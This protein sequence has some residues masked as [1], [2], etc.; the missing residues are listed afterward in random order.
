[1]VKDRSLIGKKT[2]CPKCKYRFVVTEPEDEL[3]DDEDTPPP[4]K[5]PAPSKATAGAAAAARSK[6]SAA[7]E[8]DED[9]APKKKSAGKKKARPE[10][11]EN[12]DDREEQPQTKKVTTKNKN[13][14]YI[15]IGIG[16]VALIA[17]GVGGY[18]MFG[19][20]GGGSSSGGGSVAKGGGG[21]G[22]GG[23][24]GGK[25]R[26]GGGFGKGKPGGPSTTPTD[27]NQPTR[28]TPVGAN[29]FL[30]LLP[31]DTQSVFSSD[32]EKLSRTIPFQLLIGAFRED[33]IESQLGIAT[34]NIERFIQARH[35]VQQRTF[36]IIRTRQ[37]YSEES[38]RRHLELEANE[39]V[40][41]FAWYR[42]GK[43]DL[44][45]LMTILNASL[46]QIPWKANDQ[47]QLRSST[48]WS[49]GRPMAT[50]FYDKNTLI[51][52][53][54]EWLRTFLSEGRTPKILVDELGENEPKQPDDQPPEG[55]PEQPDQPSQ[56]PQGQ[57]GSVPSGPAA[58]PEGMQGQPG[59][60]MPGGQPKFGPIGLPGGGPGQPKSP[61]PPPRPKRRPSGFITVDPDMKAVIDRLEYGNDGR[62]GQ[63]AETV[64]DTRT[65]AG[66]ALVPQLASVEGD[67]QKLL[68]EPSNLIGLK[69]FGHAVLEYS[70][71]KFRTRLVYLFDRV[72]T[73]VQF[74]ERVRLELQRLTP[75]LEQ[76]TETLVVVQSNADN[77]Q[78]GFPGD[79][80]GFPGMPGPGY[81]KGGMPGPGYPK[82]S[83]PG[84]GVVPGPGGGIRPGGGGVVPGPGGG[85]RPGG[86]GVVPGPGGIRPGGGGVMPGPGGIRPGGGGGVRPGDPDFNPGG[87]G[88]GLPDKDAKVSTIELELADVM[89]TIDFTIDLSQGTM[90]KEQFDEVFRRVGEVRGYTA[91]RTGQFDRI[92]TLGRSVN[93]WREA[94]AKFPPG[95]LPD[96]IAW[97]GTIPRELEGRRFAVT[98]PPN[99]RLSWMVNLLP[100]LG[101]RNLQF[102]PKKSWREQ[103]NLSA[104][105]AWIPELLNPH[106]PQESWRVRLPSLKGTTL[107]ATH[108]VGLSGIGLEASEFPNDPAFAKKLGVF[109]YDRNTS[110]RDVT[111]G[112]NQTIFVIQVPPLPSRPWVAGGGATVQGVPVTKSIAPFVTVQP[113]G[114]HKGKAGTYAVMLDGSVRF[115]AADVSD[116]VFKAMVTIQGDDLRDDLDAVA[117][118]VAPGNAMLKG[119]PAKAE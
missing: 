12:L 71:A 25:V 96:H 31:N 28:P 16:V 84:G 3:L 43:P 14:L 103:P 19:G 9:A 85:I 56:P 54:E 81:P 104:G 58:P 61:T 105:A 45:Q 57:A 52:A 69:V 77:Q 114:S 89:V 49:S 18:I 83:Y 79:Q 86:G 111:D 72:N 15:G 50:H 74:E 106:Y 87:P 40:S 73:A 94:Q 44:I 22:G 47:W 1:L 37:S 55:Q 117:P 99:E 91:V 100:Y 60:P 93:D 110:F 30:A 97:R 42:I 67:W 11:E 112:L 88:Q 68:T 75:Q 2:E 53:D 118:K 38:V 34:A 98:P 7:D 65:P 46:Q 90:R 5:K 36:N 115:I 92:F 62:F 80:P 6:K 17:L 63:P 21:P 78:G 64:I 23:P 51:I 8:V 13:T 82:G 108:Y 113:G 76:K 66:M 10:P 32:V 29:A 27:P 116:D 41:G 4:A 119:G 107:G 24:G 101:Q 59:S 35:L 102:D 95:N 39:P 33:P 26:P 109:G 48:P 70:P 20:D